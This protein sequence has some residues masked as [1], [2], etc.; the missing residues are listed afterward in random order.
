MNPYL[1][2]VFDFVRVTDEAKTISLGSALAPIRPRIAAD[3]PKVLFFA[4]HPD[5]ETIGGG[6][7]LR[8]L[9]EARWNVINVAVTQGSKK[10]RQ[11]ER[12]AELKHACNY[13]GFG[14][15]QTGPFGL[16]NVTT[17]TRDNDHAHWSQMVKVIADILR[18]Q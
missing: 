5:D 14:L 4:P 12:L 10:E 3:A 1:K 7:A 2:F 9:R 13:I 8:L 18:T 17:K 6:L 11:S 15:L 16:E